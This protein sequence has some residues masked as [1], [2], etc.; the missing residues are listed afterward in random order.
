MPNSKLSSQKG[1]IDISISVPSDLVACSLGF[2]ATPN[3][4]GVNGD[5]GESNDS[6]VN[7]DPGESND[8]GVNGDP[9]E[10]GDDGGD[11]GGDGG[12]GEVA[13]NAPT[14]SAAG[15]L[16]ISLLLEIRSKR[17]TK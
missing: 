11:G 1:S 9:G 16:T 13:V 14:D 2:L 10:G 4:S 8:S 5:P 6:G 12:G 7:G 15:A 3:D 17:L